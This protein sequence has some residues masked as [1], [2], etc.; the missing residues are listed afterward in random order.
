MTCKILPD[1]KRRLGQFV[2]TPNFTL[3]FRKAGAVFFFTVF[4]FGFLFCGFKSLA[5]AEE[6][7]DVD[8]AR[9]YKPQMVSF[10]EYAKMTQEEKKK[11]FMDTWADLYRKLRLKGQNLRAKCMVEKF[12]NPNNPDAFYKLI[13]ELEAKAELEEETP[14]TK[15]EKTVPWHIARR[16]LSTCPNQTTSIGK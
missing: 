6:K 9:P 1:I 10:E 3:F 12:S 7:A 2:S 11:I 16:I 13:A 15:Y 8:P 5:V 14:D 4:I